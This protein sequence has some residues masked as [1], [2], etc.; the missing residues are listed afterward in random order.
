MDKLTD[1]LDIRIAKAKENLSEESRDAINAVSWKLI[2]SG[3]N[4]AYS[5][6]QLESLETETELLLCGLLSTE[7]Y[8]RE[9]ESRMHLNKSEVEILI[10]EID[11][12]IFKKI[13]EGL[14]K[15]LGVVKKVEVIYKSKPLTNDPNL[16]NTPKDVQ[17]AVSLSNW[18][19]KLYIISK[20]YGLSVEKMGELEDITVKTLKGEILA[21]KYEN[22][23][24]NRII[25]PEGREKEMVSE[26]NEEIFRVIKGTLVNNSDIIPVESKEIPIPPYSKQKK[27][28]VPLPPPSY[29]KEEIKKTENV[30]TI[31]NEDDLYKEHGIEIISDIPIAKDN[32]I[33]QPKNNETSYREEIPNKLEK[34]EETATPIAI[35]VKENDTYKEEIPNI[36]E[37]N[38]IKDKLLGSTISKTVVNDYSLPKITK[39]DNNTEIEVNKTV[40]P[41]DPYHEA[42]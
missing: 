11:K 18:K 26:I 35:P 28:T 23:V 40:N 9:L 15:R 4:N 6:D 27:N 33:Y 1:T 31:K 25:V 22:E 29:K 20:K 41:H 21:S 10:N 3:I 24:K 42:I 30:N 17:T 32:N 2:L 5:S 37:K 7:D 19:E 36:L 16:I 13:Q 34:V 8:P 38:I 39:T 12:L 14:E